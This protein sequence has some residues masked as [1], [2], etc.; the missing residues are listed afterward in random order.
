MKQILSDQGPEFMS[1][2]FSN[3]C[4][5]LGTD[6][7]HTSPYSPATNGATERQNN[8]NQQMLT[9]Y[10]ENHPLD[11]DKHLPCLPLVKV[12]LIEN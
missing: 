12:Y 9:I 5:L 10:L 2:V 8:V 7:I 6:K 11:W 3:L 1:D 4:K